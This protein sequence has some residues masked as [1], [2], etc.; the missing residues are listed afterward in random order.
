M[1]DPYELQA[2]LDSLCDYPHFWGE[3]VGALYTVI[4]GA[5]VPFFK[6]RLQL[7]AASVIGP[8]ATVNCQAIV[9]ATWQAV[10]QLKC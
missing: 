3:Q 10:G 1:D 6:V 2:E 5:Q 8:T 9:L 7:C 4:L